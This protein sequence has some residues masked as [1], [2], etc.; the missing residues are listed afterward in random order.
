MKRIKIIKSKVCRNL[1]FVE[2]NVGL[3]IVVGYNVGLDTRLRI[4]RRGYQRLEK[5]SF[6]RI[7]FHNKGIYA[8]RGFLE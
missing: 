2:Y 8:R 5:F 7:K 4:Q 6:D 3:D 1:F